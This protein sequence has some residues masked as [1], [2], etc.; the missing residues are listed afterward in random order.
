MATDQ[1][2]AQWYLVSFGIN[3]MI[4][5]FAA[6]DENCNYERGMEV[7]IQTDRGEEKGI[8]LQPVN[9]QNQQSIDGPGASGHILSR[10]SDSLENAPFDLHEYFE[11]SRE[12][13]MSLFLPVQVVDIEQ[14]LQPG[15]V[16]LH[17]IQF[18][19]F[20]E[21]GLVAELERRW[22]VPVQLL[23]LTNQALLSETEDN[24]SGC[25]SGSCGK[26]NCGQCS[27]TGHSESHQQFQ[28][29]WQA[30]L[31]QRRSQACM[32]TEA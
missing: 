22:H 27:C 15:R 9:S 32:N 6:T 3:G 20:D 25:S 12:I 30:Y 17:L 7:L 14:I 10:F 8:I 5:C 29:S 21:A 16:V 2:T 19:R 28:Q 4:G 13:V 1:I 26:E 23:N 31:T 18:G 24:C 11:Q